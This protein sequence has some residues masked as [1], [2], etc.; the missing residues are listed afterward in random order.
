MG[1]VRVIILVVCI[2]DVCLVWY[3]FPGVVLPVVAVVVVLLLLLGP[4]EGSLVFLCFADAT[5]SIL[6][7]GVPFGSVVGTYSVSTVF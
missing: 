1:V 3:E 2:F 5:L 7:T 4:V 6:T